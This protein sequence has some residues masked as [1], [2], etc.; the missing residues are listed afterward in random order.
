MPIHSLPVFFLFLLLNSQRQSATNS[1]LAQR[2]LHLSTTDIWGWIILFVGCP[3]HGRMFNSISGLCSLNARNILH[4]WQLKICPDTAKYPPGPLVVGS[5][6]SGV[7]SVSRWHHFPRASS[8]PWFPSGC[9]MWRGLESPVCKGPCGSH[10]VPAPGGCE[11]AA[12]IHVNPQSLGRLAI[13]R[14]SRPSSRPMHLPPLVSGQYPRIAKVILR[15]KN[16]TG[17]INLPDFRLYYKA[18]VIKQYGTG[19]KTEI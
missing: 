18:T 1:G 5:Y 17:G 14:A 16:G 8:S 13:P 9:Q 11:P 2:F 10:A 3:L 7:P 6:C 12:T 19:T 4:L 15:K